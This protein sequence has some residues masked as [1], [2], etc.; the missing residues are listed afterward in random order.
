MIAFLGVCVLFS[1]LLGPRI[2]SGGLVTRDGF[3]VYGPLGKALLFA[4]LALLLLGR[5]IETPRLRAWHPVHLVWLV[6]GAISFALAWAGVS[7]LLD[8]NRAIFT[9]ASTHVY[10]WASLIFAAGGCFGAANLRLLGRAYRRQIGYAALAGAL[11]YALLTL[12]Y[13]LWAVLAGIVLHAVAVL[14]R[15]IGLSVAL[16]PPRTLL[17]TKFGITVAQTCSGIESLALFSGLYGLIGMLDWPRLNHRRFIATFVPAMLGL[18]AFNILRVFALILGG[19]YINPHIAFSLFHTYAGMVFFILYALVFWAF[20]YRWM[21]QR[22]PS[23]T[24]RKDS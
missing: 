17:L 18:F 8:G 21:L 22:E 3:G 19:Y 9:I 15:L 16:I 7:R 4:A 20:A 11:F 23:R 5:R 24:I 12:I 1:G 14:L 10:M 6:L 2:I 13:G